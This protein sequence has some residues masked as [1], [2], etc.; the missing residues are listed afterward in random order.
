[1]LTELVVAPM[2]A[3]AVRSFLKECEE[4]GLLESSQSGNSADGK[5]SVQEGCQWMVVHGFWSWR[6]TICQPSGNYD[7][8]PLFWSFGREML[9][10]MDWALYVGRLCRLACSSS[11]SSWMNVNTNISWK[12]CRYGFYVLS[13][14]TWHTSFNPLQSHWTWTQYITSGSY[15]QKSSAVR[16]RFQWTTR[17]RF[18][19]LRNPLQDELPG[20]A[21]RTVLR[22]TSSI[23]TLDGAG[24]TTY[25]GT[26]K[27]C[28]QGTSRFSA[29]IRLCITCV[30][31]TK[32]TTGSVSGTWLALGPPCETWS[33]ARFLEHWLT[34]TSGVPPVASWH[35]TAF[36]GVAL[37]H[38][39]SHQRWCYDTWT[40][41]RASK[42][43]KAQCVENRIG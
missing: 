1:M 40:S 9:H 18:S 14:I 2:L 35:E 29:W 36:E 17:T 7:Q 4:R 30:M 10:W 12:T 24:L 34:L 15:T 16:S 39:D 32:Q 20:E 13:V 23:Y 27:R 22:T 25:S 21:I 26:L 28:T 41:S 38:V 5:W 8:T 33:S 19:L 3:A 37:G 43:W 6:R 42:G 11:T 31:S